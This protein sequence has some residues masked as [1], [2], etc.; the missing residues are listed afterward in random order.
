M[1]NRLILN[2][3]G[4]WLVK[5]NLKSS[6]TYKRANSSVDSGADIR[7][8]CVFIFRLFERRKCGKFECD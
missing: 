6:C 4:G 7:P 2:V 8:F 5:I 1:C 3:L